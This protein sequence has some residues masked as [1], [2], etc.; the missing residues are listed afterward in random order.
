M[1]DR[2]LLCT[3]LLAE[4]IRYIIQWDLRSLE[5]LRPEVAT[6]TTLGTLQTQA[7]K[8]LNHVD[9]LD[10]ISN[11]CRLFDYGGTTYH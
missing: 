2:L 10:S 7:F 11:Y 9:A 3:L 8:S 6:P 1:F 5:T 4:S